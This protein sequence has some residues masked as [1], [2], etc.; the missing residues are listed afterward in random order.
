MDPERNWYDM[1]WALG[2]D[3]LLGAVL[4]VLANMDTVIRSFQ[5]SGDGLDAQ[6]NAK[7]K[8]DGAK[9]APSAF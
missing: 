5:A 8:S 1:M 3:D 4:E 2:D 6:N 9:T 7:E